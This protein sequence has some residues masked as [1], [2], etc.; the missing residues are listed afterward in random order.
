MTND[1]NETPVPG[2]SGYAA[3]APAAAGEFRDLR[4]AILATRWNTE[5]VSALVGGA[6][7]CLRDWHVARTQV[8]VMHVPGSMELPLAAEA[9]MGGGR[10]S[11]VIALGVVIRGDTLHFELVA[12]ES[13]RGLRE[14]SQKHGVPLGCGVLAV[15]NAR[16]AADR[17]GPGNDNKGYEAAAAALEMV[18]LLRAT[19]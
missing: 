19:R 17:S 4:V 15:E 10:F 11:A 8:E 3:P 18:R 9:V 2:K 12:G 14:A 16:Q 5:L 6:R 13:V 1:G 7:R